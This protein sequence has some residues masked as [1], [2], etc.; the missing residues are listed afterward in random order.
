M[1]LLIYGLMNF[2]YSRE[3]VFSDFILQNGEVADVSWC[4]YGL[5]NFNLF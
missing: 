1:L 3:R 2:I 4:Y 5:M